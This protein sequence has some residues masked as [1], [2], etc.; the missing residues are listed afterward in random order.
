MTVAKSFSKRDFSA[1]QYDREYQAAQTDITSRGLMY[2]RNVISSPLREIKTRPGTALKRV[3]DAESYMVPYRYGD[4]DVVLLFSDKKLGVY[5]FL[6][7]NSLVP[8]LGQINLEEFKQTWTANT[9]NGYTVSSSDGSSERYKSFNGQGADWSGKDT[10][11]ITFQAPQAFILNKFYVNWITSLTRATTATAPSG[12]Q[13][14]GFQSARIVY[15][16]DGVNWSDTVTSLTKPDGT[17]GIYAHMEVTTTGTG[18]TA[19]VT[20]RQYIEY[21]VA[22]IVREGHKYWKIIF[23]GYT[24]PETPYSGLEQGLVCRIYT[25]ELSQNVIFDTDIGISDLRNIKYSQYGSELKIATG[26]TIPYR[27]SISN[28][29]MIFEQFLPDAQIWKTHGVPTCVCYFQ[30]RLWW[31]GFSGDQ[32]TVIGSAFGNENDYTLPGTMLASSPIVAT[33]NQIKTRITDLFAGQDILY[34]QCKEGV[35]TIEA[36]NAAIAPN[37]MSFLL[38]IDKRSSGITP[39]VKDNLLFFV[40]ESKDTI[41]AIQFDLIADKYQ[42]S[43]VNTFSHA[44]LRPGIKEI[45]YVDTSAR[46]IYGILYNGQMFALLYDTTFNVVGLFPFSTTG[47]IIDISVVETTD[48]LRLMSVTQR[49]GQYAIEM[50]NPVQDLED[51]NEFEQSRYEANQATKRNLIKQPFMDSVVFVKDEHWENLYF[52]AKSKILRNSENLYAWATPQI[53]YRKIWY[54]KSRNPI[55]GDKL[56]DADGKEIEDY[57]VKNSSSETIGI[58]GPD[59]TALVAVYDENSNILV[60]VTDLSEYYQSTIRFFTQENASYDLKIVGKHSDNEY[61]VEVIG[62][63]IDSDLDFV[64]MQMPI[65]RYEPEL[66]IP[67]Q[68]Y[69]YIDSGRYMGN[70]KAEATGELVFENPVYDLIY[71][72]PYRKIAVVQDNSHYLRKK[73][74]GAIA[75]NVMDTMSLQIG[76]RIDKMEDVMRWKGDDFYDSSPIMRNGIL[77]KSIADSPEND[78]KLILMTDEGLPFC[79]R[80]IEAAG[81]VTDRNGN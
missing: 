35:T 45:H 28:G 40:S 68:E 64:K 11:E 80:A 17:S 76:A 50:F 70:I 73:K 77:I 63:T 54:T 47:N 65:A 67:S 32:R 56:Y 24:Q 52:D 62:K 5:E 66:L 9:T 46:L 25:N 61:E 41:Y 60:N 12:S 42:V 23:S 10:Y 27:F 58:T 69:Q 33:C 13:F 74:W 3:L 2:C 71:G 51:T 43:N 22:P 55:A 72:I 36:G 31:G 30:N 53:E 20:Q 16:D 59:T 18:S 38:K 78:K 8:F 7:D 81:E 6:A 29:R 48:G 44:F 26:T 14:K 21:Y 37:N 75:L 15:S 34:A 1:G 4:Q 39:T 79:I 49:G 19:R 57:F